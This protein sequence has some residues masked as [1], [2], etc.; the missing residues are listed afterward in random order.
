MAI[1]LIDGQEK[2][3][4]TY[5]ANTLRNMQIHCRKGAILLD[6]NATGH[7][8][9]LLEKILVGITMPESNE[10]WKEWPWK[11]DS[12]IILV[13]NSAK[14]LD[15]CEELLPGFTEFFGPVYTIQIGKV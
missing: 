9:A 12:M 2:S 7:I 11:P 3:G 10:K 6:E 5:L 8:S 4:K 1:Y 15:V 13:G 14:F